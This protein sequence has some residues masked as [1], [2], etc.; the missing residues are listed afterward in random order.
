MSALS[1]VSEASVTGPAEGS[2]RAYILEDDM[3]IAALVKSAKPS[4]TRAQITSALTGSALDIEA[5]GTDRDSGAGIVMAASW[6]LGTGTVRAVAAWRLDYRDGK[7]W[8]GIA[9]GAG[10]MSLAVLL[11]F[12]KEAF[13]GD[14]AR[15]D[16]REDGIPW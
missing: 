1:G 16:D 11:I 6:A 12:Y 9:A 3:A 15:F 5:P 7:L 4:A 2:P 10:C 8:L 14:E 13:L